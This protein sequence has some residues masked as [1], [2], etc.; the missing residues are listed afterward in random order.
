[1]GRKEELT[2]RMGCSYTRRSGSVTCCG[3]VGLFARSQPRIVV[4]L[5][6]M[7]LAVGPSI[8]RAEVRRRVESRMAPRAFLAPPLPAQR[9]TVT[10]NARAADLRSDP[11]PCLTT[12][13]TP[14]CNSSSHSRSCHQP[15]HRPTGPHHTT[16]M[17]TKTRQSTDSSRSTHSNSSRPKTTGEAVLHLLRAQEAYIDASERHIALLEDG[18]SARDHTIRTSTHSA[19]HPPHVLRA[20]KEKESA[21]RLAL[22][23]HRVDQAKAAFYAMGRKPSRSPSLLNAIGSAAW[24]QEGVRL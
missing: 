11:M 9:S 6:V 24:P 15:V 22:L 23:A 21:E 18:I 14:R 13:Q 8:R 4:S 17:S 3:E 19:R 20:R 10:H 2:A 16:T 7:R 1:M 5:D 12:G